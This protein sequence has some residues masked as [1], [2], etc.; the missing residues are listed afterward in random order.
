VGAL[1]VAG[2]LVVVVGP[3]ISR[4]EKTLDKNPWEPIYIEQCATQTV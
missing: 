3:V 2:P 1:D 4:D